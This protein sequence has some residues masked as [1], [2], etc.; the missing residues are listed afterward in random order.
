MQDRITFITR[1]IMI[2]DGIEVGDDCLF[3]PANCLSPSPQGGG[4]GNIRCVA[5][6]NGGLTPASLSQ[7]ICVYDSLPTDRRFWDEAI[8][9]MRDRFIQKILKNIECFRK[10]P[11]IIDIFV[12]NSTCKLKRASGWPNI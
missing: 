10:S 9:K 1:A 5:Q 8:E 3:P 2:D 11:S 12:S 7:V 6:K 4:L